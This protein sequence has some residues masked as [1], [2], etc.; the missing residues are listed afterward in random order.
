[1]LLLR[2][3]ATNHKSLRDE[4]VLDLTR[5]TLR[6]LRPREGEG[7]NQQVYPVAGIFGANASGKS[8]VLDAL[9]YALA[10]V[11]FSA[12]EWQQYDTV[13]HVPFAL[14][15]VHPGKPSCYEFDFVVG[16]TRYQY[17]F[18]LGGG[19]IES[20]WLRDLPGSRF[21]SLLLRRGTDIKLAPGVGAIGPLS[22]RELALS[23]AALLEHPRLT[24]ITR[25]LNETK[26]VPFG[27][28]VHSH[29]TQDIAESVASG[30]IREEL[31]RVL[32]QVA[33]VGI[34]GL[35]VRADQ[36]MPELAEFLRRFKDLLSEEPEG[37]AGAQ[38]R[39]SEEQTEMV[40]RNLEFTHLGS[41]DRRYTFT[42]YD[43]SSG[44]LAWLSLALYAVQCLRRGNVM[45]VDEIDASLH[46][47]LM[48]VLLGWFADPEINRFG[49]QLIFTSHDTYL[50]SP[51]A[52]VTL[53][54]E[55]VWFTEKERDGSSELYSLAD[56][57]R[58]KDANV[59]RR[60][61][62]GRYGAIPAPAPSLITNLLGA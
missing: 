6:T 16:E 47:H 19:G 62:A 31:V 4:A 28:T 11:E 26:V 38:I 57:K 44:T 3:S 22:R 55:Q 59:A 30:E 14:D 58:H 17:G 41:G 36:I 27:D 15:E 23:R 35:S 20:E 1:M 24:P 46:S 2:F 48:E 42:I 45:V 54:P 60:Y 34:C 9:R 39:L 21:R 43:E 7:W 32:L 53:E 18:E 10:V 29:R 25:A 40:V 49:A 13:P 5:P 51:L 33:D 50:L 61:L 12:G 8:T 56:F 37:D 52:S